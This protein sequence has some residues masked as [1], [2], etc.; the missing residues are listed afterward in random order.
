MACPLSTKQYCTALIIPASGP[1]KKDTDEGGKKGKRIH[2][3]SLFVAWMVLNVV[4][5]S[6]AR[7]HLSSGIRLPM[8]LPVFVIFDRS[9]GVVVMHC[10]MHCL[11]PLSPFFSSSLLRP[12]KKLTKGISGISRRACSRFSQ[13]KST[14]GY[15]SLKG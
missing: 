8:L 12:P 4:L 11:I 9:R 7:G 2:L 10:L 6:L 3:Y 14:S 1:E 15:G 13:R 5:I